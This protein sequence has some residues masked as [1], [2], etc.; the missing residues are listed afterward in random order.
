MK[1]HTKL[2]MFL[3]AM[4]MFFTAGYSIKTDQTDA[5]TYKT[6]KV[7][8]IDTGE[9]D[10]ILIS[11]N[12]RHMLID[13]GDVDDVKTIVNY[14]KKQKV[15]KLDY[16]ILTHPHAD[17]IGAASAVVNTFDIGKIIMSSKTNTTKVYE[18]LLDTIAKKKLKITKPVVGTSYNIGSAKFTLLA[19]NSYNYGSNLN[20]YSISLRLVNG[21]N[22]FM[23][24]GDCETEA[25]RDILKNKQN[26]NSDVLLCGHHGSTTSTN[27]S[28]LKAVTP[29]YA[30]IS[31][32]KNN[33]GHPSTKTLS[34]LKK[35][36]IKTYRTDENGTIIAT[37]TGKKISFSAKAT[38]LSKVTS[39]PSNSDSNSSSSST[40]TTSK[41]STTVYITNS[42]TKYHKAGCR[43]IKDS[44]IKTTIAKAKKDKYTP[45]KVCKP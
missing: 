42:G 8:Y 7:H 22:S 25:I 27:S 18:N 14:L 4:F 36:K 33:Y 28:L 2:Y 32:G 5:A 9:S 20:N 29:T 6:M 23:F 37:S 26:L 41:D 35:D 19:P 39:T 40:T 16:L 13:A 3:L 10:S 1:K 45:C 43:Y 34:L 44:K 38:D 17:H 21:K 31:V 15:K 12:G 11:S 30:V 24:I